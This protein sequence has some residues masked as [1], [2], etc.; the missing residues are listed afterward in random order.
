MLTC[1][2]EAHL[3]VLEAVDVDVDRRFFMGGEGGQ[4]GFSHCVDKLYL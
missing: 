2:V 4:N 3:R 1:M